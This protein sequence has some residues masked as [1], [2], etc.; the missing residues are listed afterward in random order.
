MEQQSLH[1]TVAVRGKDPLVSIGVPTWGRGLELACNF[2]PMVKG[3]GLDVEFLSIWCVINPT[4]EFQ[5][6]KKM[7]SEMET[8]LIRGLYNLPLLGRK[9]MDGKEKW[10]PP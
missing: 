10:K 5:L 8:G 2:N 7:E 4:M 3:S 1:V 6:E 9:S